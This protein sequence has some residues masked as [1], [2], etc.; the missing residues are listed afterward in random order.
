MASPQLE[1]LFRDH[2][3]PKIANP[4]LKKRLEK[5]FEGSRWV[6]ELG[7]SIRSIAYNFHTRIG[8]VD[9]AMPDCYINGCVSLVRR[10]DPKVWRIETYVGNRPDTFYTYDG[11]QWATHLILSSATN[12]ALEAAQDPFGS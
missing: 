5:L 6:S 3:M 7:C 11:Y 9:M 4:K 10:I 2:P 1:K 12:P 8:R